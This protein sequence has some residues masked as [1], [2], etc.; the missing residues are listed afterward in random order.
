MAILEV[1]DLVVRFKVRRGIFRR[2]VGEVQ[3]V[4]KVSL[5]V[6]AG[7]TLGLVG[8]SGCGKTTLGRAVLR[9]VEPASGSIRFEGAEITALEPEELRRFRKQAQMIFQDPFGSLNPRMRV[10]NI[11]GEAFVIHRLAPKSE[12]RA[13]TAEILETVG[14][15]P[16][17]LD[18]FP[19]EFSGGQ[20]QRIGIARALAV[21]PKFIVADEPVSALDVS[22]QAQIL[23]LLK[24]LQKKFSLAYLFIS[25]DL[26]VVEFIAHRV[27]V[28]YLGRIMELLPA[29]SLSRAAAHPY[30]K[31][32]LSAVPSFDPE[33]RRARIL[34]AGDVPDPASPPSGCVFHPRC[35]LAEDRC[36]RETPLLR[37]IGEGQKAAC[38][39]V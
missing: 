22:I 26:R 6:A 36:K 21:H 34:L 37:P 28:M 15:G 38:H 19:H 8:E 30:T 1:K 35:P 31:A 25:H 29:R 2:S 16:E 33:T 10:R 17:T 39:L 24:E 14:L 32:L 18:K 4:E 27:A 13:R 12:V 7:E 11:V 20:R 3:A 5:D 23:N 9:L